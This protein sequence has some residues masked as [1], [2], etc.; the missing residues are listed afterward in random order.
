MHKCIPYDVAEGDTLIVNS[1]LF[2]I[3]YAKNQEVL[4]N[5]STSFFQFMG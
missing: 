2:C 4:R 5:R 3:F 1:P